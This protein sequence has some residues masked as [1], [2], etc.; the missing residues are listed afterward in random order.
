MWNPAHR[1]KKTQRPHIKQ[2]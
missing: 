1:N 2:K